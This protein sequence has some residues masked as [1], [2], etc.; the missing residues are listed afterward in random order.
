[1]RGWIYLF[2]NKAMPGLVK[3]GYTDR[4]P[5]IRVAEQ[6]SGLP[7]SHNIEYEVLVDDAHS[8]E[9]RIHRKLADKHEAKEWFRSS[10]EEAIATIKNVVGD[11]SY[12]ENFVRADLEKAEAIANQRRA[13]RKAI[14]SIQLA[15]KNIDKEFFTARDE[16]LSRSEERLKNYKNKEKETHSFFQW[17][18]GILGALFFGFWFLVGWLALLEGE[19]IFGVII[20]GLFIFGYY[21]DKSEKEERRVNS[22]GY[23]ALIR[24]RDTQI[25]S[26]EQERDRRKAE[27]QNH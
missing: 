27:L 22:A 7:Y 13:E 11:R 21:R 6:H 8:L 25:R 20:L 10:V 23:K 9:Q 19:L 16:V 14:E 1:V 17:T 5:E 12:V 4:D 18:L 26:L 2:T 3:I 15:E 24:E